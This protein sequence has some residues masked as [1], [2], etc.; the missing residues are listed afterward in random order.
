M[1]KVESPYGMSPARLALRAQREVN[2]FA[3]E[4]PDEYQR[5]VVEM[6]TDRLRREAE[7]NE[8]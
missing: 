7:L 2:K 5:I 4:H 1:E 3:R 6:V 8:P